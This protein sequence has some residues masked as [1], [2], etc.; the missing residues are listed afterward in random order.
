MVNNNRTVPVLILGGST[1]ALA[2]A[3]GFG[4]QNIPVYISAYTSC[5]AQFSKFCITA[6]LCDPGI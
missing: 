2:L 4:P 6:Y 5:H 3:R 1:N